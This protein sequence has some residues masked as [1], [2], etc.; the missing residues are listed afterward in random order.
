MSFIRRAAGAGVLALALL[1]TAA[2][3]AA[4]QDAE[5]D[6][7]FPDLL[8][9]A[10]SLG[11]TD[12]VTLYPSEPMTLN[13]TKV[14]LDFTDLAGI[15]KVTATDTDCVTAG[16]V[17][18]CTEIWPLHL[19]GP[20]SILP[21]LTVVP[22]AG[23]VL[24]AE[25]DV[26]VSVE[27]DGFPKASHTA[28]IKIAEGVDVAAGEDYIE[29]Q[30]GVGQAFSRVLPVSNVGDKPVTG[31][32]AVFYGDYAISAGAQFSNC[33]YARGE[34]TSCSFGE[35]LDV[36][37][38]YRTNQPVPFAIRSD[39]RAPSTQG[40]EVRWMTQAEFDRLLEEV[41]PDFFGTKGTGAK[42]T[43]EKVASQAKAL[44]Q[45][46]VD[47]APNNNWATYIVSVTG[48]NKTD[49]AAI[50]DSAS[51]AV[52]DE[53]VVDF[54]VK[55]LG[56]A[57]TDR[58]RSGEL[59]AIVQLT[60]PTGTTAITVPEDCMPVVDGTPQWDEG[61]KPGARN[62]RCDTS[63]FLLAG[64]DVTYPLTLRIDTATP[65]AKGSVKLAGSGGEEDVVDHNAS[66]DLADIV[67]NP[68]G[69]GLPITGANVTI[70]AATG[71]VLIA[72][73]VALFMMSRRR[74]LRIEA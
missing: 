34:L 17:L 47:V 38:N 8:I 12:R 33:T 53:V 72:G 22:L 6:L 50:G 46:Q 36:G 71:A 9:G 62:Y 40:M 14:V 73:G 5:L 42:L 44:Q 31:T 20:T 30:V 24:G 29:L 18:T 48:D 28:K 25:G 37:A 69:G 2:A 16:S 7:H 11:A 3:P 35:T 74:R 67:I 1:A 15:A 56:P 66:N 51:G 65:N 4:A 10:D 52:G 39:T 61:G 59:V 54:G 19:Y 43:L 49:L 27:A 63:W 13:N 70:V 64:D 58:G 23:A 21:E 57:T 68:Q 45:E 26:V 55:N 41:N 32:V 60:V